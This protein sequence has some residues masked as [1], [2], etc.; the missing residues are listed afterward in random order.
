[1][2]MLW[3]ILVVLLVAT[4]ADT[5]STT[6]QTLEATP[7][8]GVMSSLIA[9]FPNLVTLLNT[10][11]NITL[12]APNDDAFALLPGSKIS[13]L[14][15]TGL[16]AELTYHILNDSVFDPTNNTIYRQFVVT[17]NGALLR[18]DTA[19]P[20]V[21][22]YFGL[23]FA[24]L[25]SSITTS[26][27]V[28]HIVDTVMFP[29]LSVTDTANAGG[30]T[31]F[32]DALAAAGLTGTANS[33]QGVTVFIATNAAFTAFITSGKGLTSSLMD[34]QIISQVL[35]STDVRMAGPPARIQANA[36]SGAE[37]S[38]YFQRGEIYVFGP[39]TFPQ[40]VLIQDIL[41]QGGIAYVIKEILLEGSTSMVSCSVACVLLS[42]LNHL[43]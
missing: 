26:N 9:K 10:T 18:I 24:A 43:F 13:S 8:L 12:F 19:F 22:F 34:T 16:E 41:V 21:S 5:T 40:Q 20:N 37:I 39:G 3:V 27:G 17:A 14:S 6:L 42:I 11:G 33:L 7:N 2:G 38:I 32:N 4:N 35:F 30:Y 1:V 36:L 28:I 15:S 31:Q 23:D 25:N 29:P